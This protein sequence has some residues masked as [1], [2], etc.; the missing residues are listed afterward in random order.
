MIVYLFDTSVATRVFLPSKLFAKQYKGEERAELVKEK[1]KKYVF[2][3]WVKKQ[4]DLFLPNFIIA[5]TLFL[6]AQA[7]M[8]NQSIPFEKRIQ[9]YSELKSSFI[10]WVKYQP[11][12]KS[13]REASQVN[14]FFNYEL[15]RHHILNLDK[16][17]EFDNQ[18]EPFIDKEG[19]QLALSTIDLLL[20]SVGVELRRLF[21]DESVYILTLDK[22]LQ[23]VC[24]KWQEHLP[25]AILVDDDS[26]DDKTAFPRVEQSEKIEF[27]PRPSKAPKA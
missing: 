4:A 12:V 15:N 25:R 1:I 26:F 9:K 10:G 22:R 7:T 27:A 19:K 5:E 16:I 6:F 23:T 21:G 3:Q 2:P 18:T 20:V 24:M 13:L 17:M 14:R 11:V 8:R